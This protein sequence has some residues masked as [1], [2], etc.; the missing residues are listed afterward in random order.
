MGTVLDEVDKRANLALT[1][2]MEMLIFYLNDKQLYGIN[3]FKIIEIIEC[4]KNITKMPL[5]NPSI[6]GTVDFRGKAV[7]VIDLG[8][9]LGMPPLDYKNN[10]TYIIICEYNNAINGFLINSP[11]SLITRGWDEIKSPSGLL[12]QTSSY[13][14]AIAYADNNE[15]IQLLDIEKILAEIVG[16]N[17]EL[18]PEMKEQISQTDGI[19]RK[20]LVVDDSK[21]AR[22]MVKTVLDQ[23]GISCTVILAA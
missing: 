21:T 9:V 7:V 11:D 18:S 22:L 3:V 19:G 23:F 6:R 2:Q 15:T 5:S 10:I 1:N 14:T 13:L 20:V 4:P 16:I 8:D 12:S 17:E